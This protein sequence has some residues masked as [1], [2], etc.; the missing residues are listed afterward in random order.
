[1]L[2]CNID[3]AWEFSLVPI[4]LLNKIMNND[5]TAE[6]H[7]KSILTPDELANFLSISKTTVY[8]LIGKRQ[9][10]FT[11][12]GGGIRFTMEDIMGYLD[13]NRVDPL[14]VQIYERKKTTR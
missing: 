2:K 3:Q 6:I 4:L 1:M 12:V 7:N 10:P 5:S 13:Q 14:N 8:R 11:K 9:I